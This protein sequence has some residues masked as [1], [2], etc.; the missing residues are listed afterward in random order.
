[1]DDHFPLSPLR[2]EWGKIPALVFNAFSLVQAPMGCGR[3]ACLASNDAR[4]FH[5]I[6]GFFFLLPFCDGM[7]GWYARSLRTDMR[8]WRTGCVQREGE[9]AL[10]SV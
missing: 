5:D 9:G 10:P 4:K 3:M 6:L 8:A 7:A 2:K 1:M